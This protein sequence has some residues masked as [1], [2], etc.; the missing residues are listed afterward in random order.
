[1]SQKIGHLDIIID[2]KYVPVLLVYIES[3]I[4]FSA[5]AFYPLKKVTI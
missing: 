3:Y 5:S 4:I 2:S 1:M